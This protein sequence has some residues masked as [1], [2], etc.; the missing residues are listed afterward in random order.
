MPQLIPTP[1]SWTAPA[2]VNFSLLPQQEFLSDPALLR[3]WEGLLAAGDRLN[4]LY[5]SPVWFEHLCGSSTDSWSLGVVRDDAK[6]LLAVAP[7]QMRPYALT[8]GALRRTFLK[9]PLATAF[10]PP[11]EPIVPASPHV[12]QTLLDGLFRALPGCNCFFIPSVRTDS[13]L[14][15]YLHED[16]RNSREYFVYVP[17]G[18]RTWHWLDFGDR[19]DGF[20]PNIGRKGRYNLRRSVRCL[21]EKGGGKVECVRI[22][23]EAQVEE[24]LNAAAAVSD[25]SWQ[26]RDIGLQVTNTESDAVRYKDLVRHGLLRSYLLKCG[27]QAIAYAV[28]YE[29][30][31]VFYYVQIA[32]DESWAAHSPGTVLLYLLLEDLYNNSDSTLVNFGSGDVMY[33]SR[34]SNNQCK[35]ATVLLLRRRVWNHIVHKHHS[36]FTSSVNLAKRILKRRIDS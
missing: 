16:A 9:V 30:Q 6:R 19:K 35:D 21:E 18:L 33:K 17:E 34:F 36:W 3:E 29:Y 10:L 31:R 32:Y 11:A 7:V 12:C 8:F 28:G 22:D 26:K 2:G 5:A 27:G 23:S 25:R 1:S 15:Q 14:W 13:Y 20:L 24:F 4:L